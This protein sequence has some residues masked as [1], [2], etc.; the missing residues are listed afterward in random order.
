MRIVYIISLSFLILNYPILSQVDTT[1]YSFDGKYL[2]KGQVLNGK[3]IGIWKEFDTLDVLVKTIEILGDNGK[4]KI[5]PNFKDPN[6]NGFYQGYFNLNKIILHGSYQILNEVKH[7]KS[8]GF[9]SYGKKE[10][11]VRFYRDEQLKTFDYY[12]KDSEE[13]LSIPFKE[14]G[15]LESL[16]GM[17]S[18]G[19]PSGVFVDFDDSNQ[20]SAVGYFKDGCKIGEWSYFKSRKL[21]CKGNYYPDFIH[22]KSIYPENNKLYLV[23]K[24][25]SLAVEVYPEEVIKSFDFNEQILYLKHGNWYYFDSKGNI[26]KT[27]KYY[28]GQLILNEKRKK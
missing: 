13:Y 5:V 4:C 16:S 7:T 17:N 8:E 6:F 25:D 24:N 12:Y 18:I 22:L 26:I 3:Q 2:F 19:F 23:N 1:I 20:V 21:Y 14:N 9:Y 10:R 11:Q 27:E 15:E 28:K